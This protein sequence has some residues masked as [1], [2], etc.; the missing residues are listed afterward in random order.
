MLFVC[1]STMDVF[2]QMNL[3][4]IEPP[5]LVSLSSLKDNNLNDKAKQMVTEAAKARG[6]A[7]EM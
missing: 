5:S 4:S 6:V 3:T 1:R 7:L 2:F